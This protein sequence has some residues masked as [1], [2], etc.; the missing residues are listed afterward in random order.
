MSA[1]SAPEDRYAALVEALRDTPGVTAPADPAAPSRKFGDT[2]LKTGGKIFAM[3]AQGRLVVKLPRHRVDALV[4]AGS[5]ERFDPGHG[6]VMKEW[7]SLDPA[8]K[9]EWLPLAREALE[10]VAARA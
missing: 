1:S 3:L 9:E 8:A 2:G 7:L 4:A 6:R 5:G 10:F